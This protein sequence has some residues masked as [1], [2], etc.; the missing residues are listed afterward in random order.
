MT[1]IAIVDAYGADRSF[2]LR[3]EIAGKMW[4]DSTLDEELEVRAMAGLR[5]NCHGLQT[6]G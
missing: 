6:V 3:S 2:P 4:M 1:A 5:I